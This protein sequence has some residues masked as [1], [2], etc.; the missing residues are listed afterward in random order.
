M[1]NATHVPRLLLQTR[2]EYDGSVRGIRSWFEQVY[3]K[4]H[5]VNEQQQLQEASMDM[6]EAVQ[7]EGDVIVVPAG[8]V[9]WGG[10]L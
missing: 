8:C 6:W 5:C 4:L 3:P 1:Y 7:R 2:S 9:W 10:V